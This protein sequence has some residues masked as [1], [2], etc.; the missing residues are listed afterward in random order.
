MITT[1]FYS[2]FWC[3][4]FFL[5]FQQILLLKHDG[6]TDHFRKWCGNFTSVKV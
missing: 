5:D 1:R 6:E 4:L 2:V 3:T